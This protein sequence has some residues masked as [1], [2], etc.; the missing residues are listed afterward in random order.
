MLYYFQSVDY[1]HFE[2][3]TYG[4]LLLCK[5]SDISSEIVRT[6]FENK[7]VRGF[8]SDQIWVKNCFSTLLL[9]SV[10]SRHC[11]FNLLLVSQN[12]LFLALQNFRITHFRNKGFSKYWA[13]N[14]SWTW[15]YSNQD[16]GKIL[17]V[18]FEHKVKKHL[19]PN[20][21][22]CFISGQSGFLS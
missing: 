17:G 12:E 18:N 13:V 11:Q 19:G 7:R 3:F 8:L 16:F 21:S 4:V 10:S 2:L 6:D 9:L 5:M 1:F 20:W 14:F 22:N 15:P